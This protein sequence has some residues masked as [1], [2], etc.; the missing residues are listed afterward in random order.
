MILSVQFLHTLSHALAASTLYGPGHP[1]RRRAVQSCYDALRQLQAEDEEPCFSF[2]GRDVIYGYDA[3]RELRDWEW[4][5]RLSDM[6]VQRIEV[7]GDVSVD[8]FA[9]F[10]E[11]MHARM[12]ASATSASVNG[13]AGTTDLRPSRQTAIRFGAIGVQGAGNGDGLGAGGGGGGGGGGDEG[14]GGGGGGGGLL[15]LQ[16][17]LPQVTLLEESEAIRYIHG[18]VSGRSIVPL[19]EAEAVV[20]SLSL[21]LHADGRLLI[22]LLKIKSF[23]QYTTTHS[24]NVSVLTMALAESLGHSARDIRAVGVAGLLHDLGKVRVPPEIL[25]KPGSLSPEERE[26]LERHPGDG[27]RIILNSDRRLT[28]P[29]AVAY[30]HHV[31]INGGGYPH[32]HFARDCHYASTLVH[33][34]DVFDA[35]HTDRPYRAAWPSVKALHYIERRAG[36]EFDPAIAAAFIA[37]MQKNERSVGFVGDGAAPTARRPSGAMKRPSGA[38]VAG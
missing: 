36:R 11:D 23:D 21:A 8:D 19:V 12:M 24:I 34:C 28:L 31:M 27:A 10:I 2:L 22:P 38:A 13:A 5:T 30:E 18:E 3:I 20:R 16:S 35:L 26:L 9:M 14:G 7:L 15:D 29:A 32:R 33:V 37:L 6:G 17:T 4:A 25:T 1:A